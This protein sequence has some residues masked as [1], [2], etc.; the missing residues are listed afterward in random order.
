[1]ILKINPFLIIGFAIGVCILVLTLIRGCNKVNALLENNQKLYAINSKL[2]NDSANSAAQFKEYEQ[3]SE[4]QEG[5]ISLREN[6]LAAKDSSITHYINT[7][8]KL[9]SKHPTHLIAATDTSTTTVPNEYLQDCEEC[10]LSLRNGKLLIISYRDSVKSLQKEYKNKSKLDSNQISVLKK[11]NDDLSATIHDVINIASNSNKPKGVLYISLST[12]FFN[13]ALPGGV[14]G[15]LMYQD[16]HKRGF[17]LKC[18]GTNKGP[19]YTGGITF[20]LSF[21]KK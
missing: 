16:K 21:R 13:T 11:Q 6:Q 18:Y 14:G 1:M 9:L 4:F 17:E 2:L 8:N 5:L 7:I 19:I 3:K 12:I 10:Y 15:G 20:P